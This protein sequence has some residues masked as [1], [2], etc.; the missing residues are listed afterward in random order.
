MGMSTHTHACACACAR[1]HTRYS[2]VYSSLEDGIYYLLP[3][4]HAH[5]F[6]SNRTLGY[7][8]AKWYRIGINPVKMIVF[9]VIIHILLRS[10]LF[11]LLFR[12]G[13]AIKLMKGK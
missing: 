10:C 11:I 6:F 7:G 4:S 1:A 12:E 3:K 8:Q 9:A 13:V 5:F 2:M